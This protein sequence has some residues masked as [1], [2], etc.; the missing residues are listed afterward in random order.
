M[1]EKIEYC[2]LTPDYPDT[3]YMIFLHPIKGARVLDPYPMTF[4]YR[5]LDEVSQVVQEAVREIQG[6]GELD[7]LQHVMLLPLCFASLYPLRPEFWQNPSQH[8]D[9]MDRLRTFQPLVKTP[10]FY[11]LLVTPTFLDENGKWHLNA[12][13]PLYLS[14]NESI[15]EQFMSHSDQSV[16]ERAKCAA[17]Y[18]F[19]DPMRYN[20]E[21]QKVAAIKSKRSEFT[22]HH[23]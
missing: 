7:V 2:T 9:S 3:A 1:A 17:I 12:T 11:K 18:T 13:L 4:L 10:L 23:N 6:T 5:S 15:I 21:T 19:G 20:W 8:Y 22:K 14:M 16:D